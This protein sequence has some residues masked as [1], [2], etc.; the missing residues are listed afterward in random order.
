MMITT[1]F[2]IFLLLCF[3]WFCAIVTSWSGNNNGGGLGS[4]MSHPSF[5]N[6]DGFVSSPMLSSSSSPI[7]DE[8]YDEDEDDD[9]HYYHD[10]Y[11][12]GQ[13]RKQQQQ[14]RR[15]TRRRQSSI[16]NNNIQLITQ[17]SSR[18]TSRSDTILSMLVDHQHQEC[19]HHGH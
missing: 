7:D 10:D 1:K 8:E 3:G 19:G 11:Y 18:R 14:Q 12:R 6:G 4:G 13:S 16:L 9:F 17:C 2:N 15:R 5:N